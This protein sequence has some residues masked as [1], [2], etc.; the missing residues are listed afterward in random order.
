[1]SMDNIHSCSSIS[2][3]H[4]GTGHN[5]AGNLIVYNSDNVD[6]ATELAIAV[7]VAGM[8]KIMVILI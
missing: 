6:Y 2:Q 1:M 5:V 4:T 8:K 3:N 7:S